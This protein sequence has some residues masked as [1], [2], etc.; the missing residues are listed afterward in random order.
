VATQNP[1]SNFF[2]KAFPC[3]FPFGEGG[4][5]REWEVNIDF[6]DH[7][8]WALRYQDRQFRKH[9]TFPFVTFGIL[10]HCQVLGSARLQMLRKT[11]ERD[12]QILS[13]ITAEKLCKAQEEEKKNALISDPAVRLLHQH[14]YAMGSRVIGSDQAR[15]SLRS[16]IWATSIMLNPP[17][18]W[19]TINPCDLH[20]PIAQVFAGENI[21]MDN[22][23]ASLGPSKEKRA[24][25]IA[26]DPYVAV[27]F[28]HFL[29]KTILCVL[30]G[31]EIQQH[32]VKS[33]KGIFGHASAY[34]GLVES[35]GRG[36]LHLHML[37]WLKNAPPMEEMEK[38]L[39][40]EGFCQRLKNFVEANIRAYLPG[41]ESA[42]TIKEIPNEV[43]VA[44][45]RPPNPNVLDYDAKLVDLEQRVAQAKQVH[46]CDSRCCLITGKQGGLIC[47]R[48]APF[49]KAIEDF[50]TEQ[51]EWGM[52]PLFEF[53]NAWVP[54]L[55]I[56]ARCNNDVKF[57][58]NAGQATNI[59]FYI[60]SYQTK[61][62]GRNHNMSAVV[63]KGF[64]YHSERSTYLESLRDQQRLLLF[65]LVHMINR[66][67]ELAAPMVMLYLMGWGD[68]YRSHH[69]TAIYWSSFAT[70][71]MKVFLE[72]YQHPSPS[73]AHSEQQHKNVVD[74]GTRERLEICESSTER[75]TNLMV[76]FRDSNFESDHMSTQSSGTRKEMDKVIFNYP[77]RSS[78]DS[79]V[80]F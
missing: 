32:R 58:M 26:L 77:P 37:L 80:S 24:E 49:V 68:T 43:E 79:F 23:M 27:K 5:E 34:F 16:Q 10:Q 42:E 78:A 63:A 12:A 73:A 67:Q 75:T 3:L 71:L 4:L 29:I 65:Q 61:K 15:Y 7:I 51:G 53:L 19:I 41:L 69:Y 70:A 72:L 6:G 22:F 76:M 46:T 54:G 40:E 60:T 14:I 8:K 52:K 25:N 20:D 31:I 9:E 21:N 64:A 18:L 50:V 17:S 55:S 1:Q 57:L 44:Y 47:K 11:F 35:Q 62:Q 66:E 38:L 36:S 45:S 39:K 28:F 30:F 2:E 74:E 13:S 56:N 33:H 59:T 48:R